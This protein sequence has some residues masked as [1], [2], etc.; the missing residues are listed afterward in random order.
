LSH[1]IIKLSWVIITPFSLLGAALH[2]MILPTKASMK[3]V[4]KRIAMRGASALP[5]A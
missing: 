1:V 2:L 3:R 5:T 4:P